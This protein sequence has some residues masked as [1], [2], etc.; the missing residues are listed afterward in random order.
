M[1][2]HDSNSYELE[3]VVRKGRRYREYWITYRIMFVND[4]VAH[5]HVEDSRDRWDAMMRGER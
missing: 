1:I 3:W 4:R 2:E 5:K